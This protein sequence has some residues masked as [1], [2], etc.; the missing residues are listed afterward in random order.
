MEKETENQIKEL[1]NLEQNLQ[2][3]LMQ[4]QAFQLEL[5]EVENA[6]EELSKSSE[7]VYKIAGNIMLKYSKQKLIEEL[8]QKKDLISL[9]LKSL[10]SQE[11]NLSENTENIRKKV[12]SKLKK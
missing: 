11:K 12:L 2:S 7:E 3:V 10:D 6:S 4:K 5:N 9:R 8:K 1:Q